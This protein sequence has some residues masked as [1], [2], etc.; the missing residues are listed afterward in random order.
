MTLS[1][2]TGHRRPRIVGLRPCEMS[3]TGESAESGLAGARAWGRGHGVIA[4]GDGASL[5]GEGNAL[6]LDGG[7]GHITLRLY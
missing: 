1:E 3:R 4:A 2:R 5:W 7:D 6:E